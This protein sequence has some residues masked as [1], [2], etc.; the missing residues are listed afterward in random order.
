MDKTNFK[1]ERLDNTDGHEDYWFKT[2]SISDKELSERYM[3]QGLVGVTDVVY[4]KDDNMI[5]I[6]RVFPFNFDVIVPEDLELKEILK[7]LA[8]KLS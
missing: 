2:D 3:E 6:K 4:S 7:E 5:G 8:E 1:F